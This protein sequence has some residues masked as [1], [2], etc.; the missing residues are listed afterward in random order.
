MELRPRAYA[1]AGA[2]VREEAAW[3]GGFS[4]WKK[5]SYTGSDRALRGGA[6]RAVK[7][8]GYPRAAPIQPPRPARAAAP[9]D[10]VQPRPLGVPHPAPAPGTTADSSPLQSAPPPPQHHPPRRGALP[11]PAA[12]P[13]PHDEPSKF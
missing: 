3:N 11:E 5:G 8:R 10:P 2:G 12:P 7:R 13:P 1:C 6:G 4:P 9:A